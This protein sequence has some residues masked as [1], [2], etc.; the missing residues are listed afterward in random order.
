MINNDGQ[1]NI[2]A[3]YHYQVLSK[4]E[5]IIKNCERGDIMFKKHKQRACNTTPTDV[6]TE[7]DDTAWQTLRQVV[8]EYQKYDNATD[9]G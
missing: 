8:P 1:T 9:L 2:A 5:W 7:Y 3:L 6:G 4:E